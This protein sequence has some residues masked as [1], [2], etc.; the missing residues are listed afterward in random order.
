MSTDEVT[1]YHEAGHAYVALHTGARILSITVVPDN[2]D[3]PAR[4]GDTQVEWPTDS[5]DAATLNTK[6]VLVALAGPVAE[7]IYR[8]EPFHPGLVSEW[9]VDW[10]QAWTAAEH[11]V[12]D[13]ERRLRF[14]EETCRQVYQ[15]LNTDD[16]WAALAVIADH[17]D[18]YE[19][20]DGEAV[21]EVLAQWRHA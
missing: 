21:Q 7:M 3:G 16:H 18:A 2:D 19:M 5:M 11:L 12:D 6:K 8:D 15:L 9:A 17:L 4:H 20:M 1:V 10:Q 13:D 14:L